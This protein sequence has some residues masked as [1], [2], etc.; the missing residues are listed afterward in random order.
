MR[1]WKCGNNQIRNMERELFSHKQRF[2]GKYKASTGVLKNALKKVG[3]IDN[4]EIEEVP[5]RVEMKDSPPPLPTPPCIYTAIRDPISHFLSGYNQADFRML[6]WNEF[7]NSSLDSSLHPHGP[8]HYAVPYTPTGSINNTNKAAVE[9]LHN[10]RK[11][12]FE[13]FVK[14]L[15]REEK[16]LAKN[17]VYRHAFSMTKVLSSLAKHNQTLTAYIPTLE[18]ITSTWPAFISKTCPGAP[19]LQ[20]MPKPKPKLKIGHH[21]TSNDPLGLYQAAKD[22]WKEGGSIARALCLL[23]A[24]DY[25]CWE[26]LPAGIPDLC[27]EVYHKHAAQIF[28]RYIS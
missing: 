15:L 7:A 21:P 2:K 28:S 24:F 1:I 17:Q 23:H 12:R 11:E 4:I 26:D 20:K 16:N 22:V 10:R 6:T 3:K 14:D 8:Y 9:H 18:N 19:P 13:A 27:I 25:A 5:F